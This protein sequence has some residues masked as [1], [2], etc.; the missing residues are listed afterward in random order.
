[1]TQTS[2][3]IQAMLV[4]SIFSRPSEI[5]L[6]GSIIAA[7]DEL[8]NILDLVTHSDFYSD[9]HAEVFRR[10]T[11]L[12]RDNLGF[13]PTMLVS[14]LE[15][16][17]DEALR[18]QLADCVHEAMVSTPAGAGAIFHAKHVSGLARRR[19]A[20]EALLAGSDRI[21]R[22][23]EEDT[24]ELLG[25]IEASVHEATA[26]HAIGSGTT[27]A[28]A[29]SSIIDRQE[30]TVSY[31]TG[32][33][34]LD[35]L[36]NGGVKPG[37]YIVVGARPSVGKTAF[38]LSL[39]AGLLKANPECRIAFFSLEMSAGAISQRVLA[40]LSGVPLSVVKGEPSD[41]TTDTRNRLV[42][43]HAEQGAL[44]ERF[45]VYDDSSLTI[46]TFR[47]RVRRLVNRKQADVIVVDFLH[48]L[49]APQASHE[50]QTAEIAAI[51]RGMKAAA[52]ESQ[53]PVICLA[54][55]NRG[56]ELRENQRPRL[57]DL[58]QS[59][60]IEQD[61]DVIA[62]LHRDDYQQFD[63]DSSSPLTVHIA[64][65]RDGKTGAIEFLYDRTTQQIQESS[66]CFTN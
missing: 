21:A 54:Q 44:F 12:Y 65:N 20:N 15:A 56:V 61:G 30:P 18:N 2:H 11:K 16:E 51:S 10:I 28:A 24:D 22:A 9:A 6:I 37:E 43:T 27:V 17:N 62:L 36:V 59:G 29:L 60:S 49:T 46:E 47:S 64:K 38:A 25:E 50:S 34:N 42:R 8:D 48:L 66:P 53:V 5:S 63:G 57:A 58:R 40:S 39:S 23:G 52:K 13:D 55:L 14:N 1:M 41:W 33:Q 3:H 19:R 26:S 45:N 4:P 35:H 31:P 32:F 7:P